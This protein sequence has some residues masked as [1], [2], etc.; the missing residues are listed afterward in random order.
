MPIELWLSLFVVCLLG[1]MTPGPSLNVILNVVTENGRLHGIVASWS[2]AIGVG[3]YALLSVTGLAYLLQQSPLLFKTLSWLGV[4]YL[5]WLG[6]KAWIA[7][8]NSLTEYQKKT[9][10]NLLS[11]AIQGGLI[12]LLNPKLGLFFIA[13]FSQFVLLV[14][15]F[16]GNVI[17][18]LTPFIVDGLWYT[19]VSIFLSQSIILNKLREHST[20]INR[21]TGIIFILLAINLIWHIS[22]K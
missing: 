5:L 19:L 18:V 11:S 13:L 20:T 7:A 21:L 14:D 2:H 1:A 6:I 3:L 12:S 4:L 22:I 16:L 17:L 9:S 8:S 15:N 10:S